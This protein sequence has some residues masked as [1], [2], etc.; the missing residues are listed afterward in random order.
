MY[1]ASSISAP[2]IVLV[3]VV[4]VIPSTSRHRR[5]LP[6]A[7][8]IP[9]RLARRPPLSSPLVIRPWMFVAISVVAVHVVVP[10][11][12]VIVFVSIVVSV[13]AVMLL[14]LLLLLRG[15]VWKH[16]AVPHSVEGLAD[17]EETR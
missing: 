11:V 14:L 8:P 7:R 6:C 2:I 16:A 3:A 9:P 5:L 15:Q 1:H 10:I 4:A 13:V 12:V 17:R